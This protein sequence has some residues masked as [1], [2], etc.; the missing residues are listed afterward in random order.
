LIR[1]GALVNYSERMTLGSKWLMLRKKA[2]L[3]A[4]GLGLTF[5]PV[6]FASGSASAQSSAL[7]GTAAFWGS[8]AGGHRRHLSPV[9]V[10]LPAPVA[11][12]GTSNSTAYALLTNGSVYA[13]GTGTR[14]ELGDGGT[15]NSF[16]K[17]VRVRF[18]AGVRIAS[19]ATDAMPWDTGFA[20]DTTGHAWGWGAGGGGDLCRGPARDLLTPVELPFS[21]VTAMAGAAD[22]ATYV[23]GGILYSCGDNAYGELGT[24]NTKGDSTHPVRVKGL[25]G[26]SVTALVAGF[27]N[28]GALLSDGRYFDWGLNREGQLGDGKIGPSSDVPVQVRLPHPVRR[29]VEGG[30]DPLDGQTLAL[31]SN[32]ALYAWGDDGA[33]QLGDGRTVNEPSPVRISPPK[34][35]SYQALASGG[36]T[37]YGVSTTGRV[38]AW[39]AGGVGAVGDGTR[40]TARTP[41]MVQSGA[42]ALISS[43]SNLVVVAL[44]R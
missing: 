39:G 27:G 31:L 16:T 34:R 36:D 13:W 26:R 43:T 42:T 20:I 14:G 19:L 37:S 33:Y 17:P 30:N 15:K 2:L 4:V 18:P 29:V 8:F 12:I 35:V 6:V 11:E 44:K 5:A 23:A 24:G 32:G 3:A 9:D 1:N 10:R 38:Y 28:I 22:H 41:V 25:S 21:H 40:K 7:R